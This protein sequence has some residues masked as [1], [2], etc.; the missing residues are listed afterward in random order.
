MTLDL[1]Q[2][3][4]LVG[5]PADRVEDGGALALSYF[6]RHRSEASDFPSEIRK[7]FLQDEQPEGIIPQDGLDCSHTL[8]PSLPP[9]KRKRLEETRAECARQGSPAELFVRPD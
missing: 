3:Q 9:N 5:G 6:S 4:R 1:L 8:P 7:S 2:L